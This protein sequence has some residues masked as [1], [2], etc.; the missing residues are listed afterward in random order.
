MRIRPN[1]NT[2][3]FIIALA[4]A[5]AASETFRTY[6][7]VGRVCR[8]K[9]GDGYSIESGIDTPQSCQ[10][11]CDDDSAK[12]GAWEYEDHD[13]DN[14]ECELHYR[15]CWIAE[16]IADLQNNDVDNA[17]TESNESAPP[18][19]AAL[20]TEEDAPQENGSVGEMEAS[21]NGAAESNTETEAST[22]EG[23]KGSTN[24][25]SKI[26]DFSLVGCVLTILFI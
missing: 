12:C 18:E 26:Y 20:T 7:A 3:I 2:A 21:A 15:C 23:T 25:A 13:A 24:D 16:D 10:Q 9:N 19:A 5:C 6:V 17:E 11:K 22:P 8:P 4:D 14:K 1:T